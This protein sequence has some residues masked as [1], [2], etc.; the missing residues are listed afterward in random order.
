MEISAKR[1]KERLFYTQL[2]SCLLASA[3]SIPPCSAAES[4]ALCS[5]L[6]FTSAAAE[7]V[8]SLHIIQIDMRLVCTTINDE[9]FGIMKEVE[10]GVISF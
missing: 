9:D 8:V 6:S 4:I 5:V 2:T 10:N 3:S 1:H 7:S